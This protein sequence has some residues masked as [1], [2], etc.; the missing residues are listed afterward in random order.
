MDDTTQPTPAEVGAATTEDAAPAE[1]APPAAAAEPAAE[2]PVFDLGKALDE[3]PAEVLRRH[4]KFAGLVGSEKQRWREEYDQQ[5]KSAAEEAAAARLREAMREQARANPV[6][7]ADEWLNRDDAE[8]QRQ[9]VLQLEQNAQAEIGRQIGAAMHAIPGWGDVAQDPEA[10]AEL[11]AALQGKQGGEMLSAWN[12]SAVALLVRRQAAALADKQL[13][14]RIAQERAAW[15][16]EAAAAGFVR[17]ERPDLA[18]GGRAA[19]A[20]PEPD[21]LRDPAAWQAWYRRSNR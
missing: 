11:A 20:D 5:Q 17:T 16:T 12:A 3:A 10:L 15:D 9:R 18:R 6:A 7:F 2:A 8:Q 21:F 4:P 1:D 14:A 13:A 19:S